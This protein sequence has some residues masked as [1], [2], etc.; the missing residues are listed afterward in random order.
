MGTA[1]SAAAPE[2][3]RWP[4]MAGAPHP[5]LRPLVPR[6]YAGFTRATTPRHLILPASA[7]VP[8]VVKLEDSAYRPPQFLMGARGA[9][10]VVE[11]DCAPS[12]VEVRLGPLGAY[13][14]LGLPIARLGRQVVDLVDVLGPAGRRLGEQLRGTTPTE[15]LARRRVNS[16]QDAVAPTP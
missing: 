12:Y 2:R 13:T 16:V 3:A 6:G 11:G 15:L 9:A 8:L 7:S 5:R 4:R 1:T 14:L 10:T